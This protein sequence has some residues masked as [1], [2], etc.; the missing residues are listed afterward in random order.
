MVLNG[1]C[2]GLTMKTERRGKGNRMLAQSR[3]EVG[4][5]KAFKALPN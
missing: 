1:V 2:G 5:C 4:F 3:V